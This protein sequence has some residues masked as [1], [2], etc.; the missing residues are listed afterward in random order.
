MDKA[1]ALAQAKKLYNAG[2]IK[3]VEDIMKPENSQLKAN[4][5]AN[6]EAM[7]GQATDPKEFEKA[8]TKLKQVSTP[9]DFS[10]AYGEI[11]TQFGGNGEFVNN[12]DEIKKELIDGRAGASP[13]GAQQ[14]QITKFINVDGGIPSKVEIPNKDPAKPN[15][16]N[17][18]ISKGETTRDD[19]RKSLV[20]Y[21]DAEKD[22]IMAEI[23]K[24]F[25]KGEEKK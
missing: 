23:P 13:A 2:E 24:G 1:G 20:G 19:F 21:S 10:K 4:F 12:P 8:I 15:A 22:K 9:I 7:K 3:D 17:A 6:L 5:I 14:Q 11:I 18:T 25:F 16:G